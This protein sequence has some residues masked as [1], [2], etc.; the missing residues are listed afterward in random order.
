M[1]L[2]LVGPDASPTVVPLGQFGFENQRTL[3]S[4]PQETSLRSAP[5]QRLM[6]SWWE[7]EVHIWR[8]SKTTVPN[9]EDSEEPVVKGRKLVAKIFIKGE[10]NINSATLSTDGSLLAVSTSSDIKVF[11]LRPR[12]PEEGEGLKVSKVSI[13]SSLSAGARLLQFSP[14][15]KWLCI[16][17]S[18]GQ[19]VLARLST[20]STSSAINFYPILSKLKR[21]DRHLEKLVLLGGLGTYD[22]T[23]TQVAFSSNSALLAVSDIAGYIDT[24]VLEGHEDL[25]Q[26]VPTS[27]SDA[28]SS[29]ESSDSDSDSEDEKE[30]KPKLTFGQHWTR[31]PS[32]SSLPKLPCT[33]VVLSFR[34][35]TQKEGLTNGVVPRSTRKRPNPVSHEIPDGEDRLLVVTATSDVY[36]FE[37]LKGGLSPWSRRNPTST[38]PEEFRKTLEQVRGCIW[39]VS[40]GEKE[41]IWLY[42]I[43]WLW[44][45]DLSR[46]LPASTGDATEASRKRKRK[47][48]AG[49][50]IPD[51]QLGTGISRKVQRHVH[52][53]MYEE[54]TLVDDDAME[55]DEEAGEEPTALERLRRGSTANVDLEETGSA[56]HWHTFKYRPIL[57][58][59]EIGEGEGQG[60][61]V[62]IVERPI[63][64]ADLPPRYYGDQEWPDQEVSL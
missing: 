50:A 7:R 26:P 8:V 5:K 51:E 34:P 45:F 55:I 36:E 11:Q 19:I 25:L 29:S 13:P 12:K 20:I 37:V 58:I 21:L 46:D 15:G 10:A 43:G 14:N 3:P 9:S 48:G 57:G 47:H 17:R 42:S 23:I 4:L 24:F 62:A 59:V 63:W 53:E 56:H 18:D 64:E 49:G 41:R 60:P 1:I 30:A 2:I 52:E 22:R 54:Q 27:D 6:M 35:A 38:F 39:D 33:P 32:A 31:N 16:I 44:M 28:A 61:E 40:S